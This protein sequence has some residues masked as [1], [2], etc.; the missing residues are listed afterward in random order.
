MSS[1][2]ESFAE[3]DVLLIAMQSDFPTLQQEEAI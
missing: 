1:S 3:L 2:I